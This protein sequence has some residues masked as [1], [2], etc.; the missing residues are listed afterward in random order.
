MAT[1]NEFL[2][3]AL[4]DVNLDEQIDRKSVYKTLQKMDGPSWNAFM[5]D[6]QQELNKTKVGM[7]PT[8]TL[9][10]VLSKVVGR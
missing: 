7:V 5:V 4:K 8:D 10:K 6:I 1:W 2:N 3:R 9:N